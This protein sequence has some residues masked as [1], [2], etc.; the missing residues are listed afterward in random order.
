[1]L[2]NNVRK[3]MC[4]YKQCGWCGY[5]HHSW[6]KRAKCRQMHLKHYYT[7]KRGGAGRVDDISTVVDGS[8]YSVA[9]NA[10]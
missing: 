1:M 8:I 4:G 7:L 6:R 2:N 5:S 10:E 9:G 3:D